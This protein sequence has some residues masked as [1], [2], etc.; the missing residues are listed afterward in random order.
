MSDE[1]QKE[2]AAE[3][4]RSGPRF[5]LAALSRGKTPEE[6]RAEYARAFDWGPDVGLEIVEG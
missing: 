3:C 2:I 4:G 1:N 6:W 5:T